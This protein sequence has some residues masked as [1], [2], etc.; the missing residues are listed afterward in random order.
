MTAVDIF[1]KISDEQMA[2]KT[3]PAFRVGDSVKVHCKIREGDKIPGSELSIVR[4]Q[5]KLED[6]KVNPGSMT[7]IAHALVEGGRDGPRQLAQIARSNTGDHGFRR[8]HPP[9]VRQFH[10]RGPPADLSAVMLPVPQ[11]ACDRSVALHH[12]APRPR[13]RGDLELHAPAGQAQRGDVH[14]LGRA[15]HRLVE[16]REFAPRRRLC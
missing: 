8:H 10:A 16:R 14:D 13:T 2:G 9:P 3:I 5:R 11:H 7:E 4:V 6:S 15:L 12:T 1:K